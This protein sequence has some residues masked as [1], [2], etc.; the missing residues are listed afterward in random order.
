[1]TVRQL[2]TRTILVVF[3]ALLVGAGAYAL[4]VRQAKQY[5][6]TTQLLFGAPTNELQLLGVGAGNQ[7]QTVA[8]ASDVLDVASFDIA[9]RTALALHDPRF[10]A[11]KVA[12]DIGV[13]NERGSNVITIAAKA[14]SPQDSAT[15]LSTYVREY[16][17]V[18]SQRTSGR[19]RVARQALDTDL[20]FLSRTQRNGIRGDELRNQI[21]VLRVFERTGNPPDIIQGVRT[22]LGPVAPQTFRNVLFGVLFG[23]I[24]GIG[25]L[26]AR[27]A[28]SPARPRRDELAEPMEIQERTRLR[29]PVP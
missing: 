27:G 26:A 25:L 29:E 2:I 3:I 20:S 11:D 12:A 18:S 7:D 9:R 16:L 19:V 28:V 4:S 14:A 8:L 22:G 17:A 13:T 6:S 5:A 21:G 1:M 15:L 23:A 10:T 24:L